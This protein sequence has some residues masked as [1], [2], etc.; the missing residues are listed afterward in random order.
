MPSN[1]YAQEL[2]DLEANHRLRKLAQARGLDFASNDYLGLGHHPALKQAIVDALDSGV[3]VGAGAS[4]LLRGNHRAHEDLE[5]FSAHFFGF[6]AALYMGNGYSANFALFTTLVGKD[7]AIFYD[8]L[9]HAS[10]RE[11]IYATKAQRFEIH[12]NDANAF[13]DALKT[14]RQTN[15]QGRAWIAVESLYSMDGDTAP[16]SELAAIAE[17]HDAMLVIDEAHATGVHGPQGKGFAQSLGAHENHIIVHTC[18]KALGAQGALICASQ[19]IKD[20]LINKCRPFIFSTGPEE[21][22]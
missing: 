7:D 1:R 6:E 5:D 18:G 22:G 16:L 13:E 19:T 14:W 21:P 12:H 4:R 3:T 11:G 15:A 8:E 9:S 20:Y 2:S 10:T 17:R